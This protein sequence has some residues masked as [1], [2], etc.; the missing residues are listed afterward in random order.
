VSPDPLDEVRVWSLVGDLTKRTVVCSP[1]NESRVK[2]W[3]AARGMDGTISVV[4]NRF[5]RDDQLI[6]M[7]TDG[8]RANLNQSMIRA[9]TE[10]S[11]RARTSWPGPCYH[12]DPLPPPKPFRPGPLP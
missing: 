3:L 1:D 7:D 5:V 8:L 6:V 9:S 10:L 4:V 12:F 11:R 2:T